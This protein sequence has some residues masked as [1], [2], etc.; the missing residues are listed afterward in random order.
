MKNGGAFILLKHRHFFKCVPFFSLFLGANNVSNWQITMLKGY[1]GDYPQQ[2]L[3]KCVAWTL[4]QHINDVL[5]SPSLDFRRYHTT[6]SFNNNHKNTYHILVSLWNGTPPPWMT[7]LSSVAPFPST[8]RTTII[9]SS[10]C[11][12]S[13]L[14]TPP[15]LGVIHHIY[16]CLAIISHHLT[17]VH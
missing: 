4:V 3:G 17:L 15:F 6:P 16:V 10:S 9:Y 2:S 1:E 12:P 11:T 14:P 5:P 8:Y 13:P 7:R